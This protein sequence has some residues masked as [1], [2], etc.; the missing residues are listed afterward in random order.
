[1][2][3]VII[4][5]EICC[6]FSLIFAPLTQTQSRPLQTRCHFPTRWCQRLWKSYQE[7]AP[8]RRFDFLHP[9]TAFIVPTWADGETRHRYRERPGSPPGS[10]WRPRRVQRIREKK[11]VMFMWL[12]L[13]HHWWNVSFLAT[14]WNVLA[15]WITAVVLTLGILFIGCLLFLLFKAVETHFFFCNQDRMRRHAAGWIRTETLQLCLREKKACKNPTW[16]IEN[17]T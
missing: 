13:L 12:A 5:G 11:S 4:N 2:G 14:Q 16:N 1:M 8:C 7:T 15:S 17:K 9:S 3:A 10:D 6:I